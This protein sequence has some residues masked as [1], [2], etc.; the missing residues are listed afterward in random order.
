MEDEELRRF[1]ALL[2]HWIEHCE[3]HAKEF[4]DWAQTV[5]KKGHS[6]AFKYMS[7]AAKNMDKVRDSLVSA[8]AASGKKP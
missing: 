5:N 8:L 2:N 4:E 6:S 7:S 1:K 3:E